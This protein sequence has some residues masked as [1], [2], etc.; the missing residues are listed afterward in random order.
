MKLT[1]SYI[2]ITLIIIILVISYLLFV[3]KESF[4]NNGLNVDFKGSYPLFINFYPIHLDNDPN[5]K[6]ILQKLKIGSYMNR[7]NLCPVFIAP[8]IG[9]SEI[10][11]KWSLGSNSTHFLKTLDSTK[12]FNSTDKWSCKDVQDTYT[13]IWFPFNSIDG[14]SEYCWSFNTKVVFNNNKFTNVEGVETITD[15][16]G[17]LNFYNGYSS[18]INGLIYLGYLKGTNL[19]GLPYDFRLMD[20]NIIT[21]IWASSIENTVRYNNKRAILI[22]HGLGCLLINYLLNKKGHAW[23]Y[24]YIE[25]FIS[26][27]GPYAGCPKALKVLINGDNIMDKN[28]TIYNT[29]KTFSGLYWMMPTPTYNESIVYKNSVGYDVITFLNYSGLINQYNST[30]SLLSKLNAP[31]VPTY[32]IYGHNVKTESCYYLDSASDIIQSEYVD[33]DGTVTLESL[34]VPKY[35]H[36]NEP[37]Y[38]K[39]YDSAEH[40]LILSMSEPIADILKVIYDLNQ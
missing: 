38:V 24:A 29:I 18:L 6:Y 25:T 12:N 37:I 21:E 36:Q 31:Q 39:G 22:G 26:I 40:T 33:G 32:I 11:A 15:N 4:E 23:S 14:L 19:F 13:K 30:M 8:T 9:A 20:V 1:N 28:H 16:I 27:S 7:S 2:Y 17:S 5:L 10:Y 34:T 35:W 3:K